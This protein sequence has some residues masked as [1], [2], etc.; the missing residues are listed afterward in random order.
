MQE[1]KGKVIWLTGASSGIGKA[2]A[3]QLAKEHAYLIL[4]S[5]SSEKLKQ[6]QKECLQFTDNCLIY[7]VDITDSESLNATY[8]SVISKTVGVDILINNA[9]QSQRSLAEETTLAV[10]RHVMDVNFFSM[11]DL[12]KL[13]LPDMIK[14]GSGHIV[15]VS[16]ITGK[17]GFPLRTAY[18]GSK[19]AVQGYF[20]SL[21]GELKKHGIY[22]TIVS[23]GRVQTD[24]SKKAIT[25]NGMAY[26]KMDS[27]QAEGMPADLCAKKIVRGVKKRRKDFLV[28][29]RELLMVYIRKFLPALY[30]NIV[31]KIKN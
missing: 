1:L 9:G 10:D 19:H 17:F 14:R 20:E 16:S 31:D 23:P 28:G 2:L 29:N 4:S 26:G 27:G 8:H 7:P 24:I 22:V 12:T 21:R 11:V 15:V 30:H 18:A 6:V 25:G 3:F 13:V 5:R